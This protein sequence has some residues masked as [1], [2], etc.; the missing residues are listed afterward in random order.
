[1]RVALAFFAALLAT[2]GAAAAPEDAHAARSVAVR[3]A[4]P[5]RAPMLAAAR[6][7]DRI[8]SVGDYG[9]VLYS[10][11]EGGSW[12]QAAVPTRETLTAVAFV[13]PRAGWAVGHGGVVL[14]TSDGGA[15]W[16]QAHAAGKDAVFFAI[17][18]S[19]PQHGLAVGAFGLAIETRDGGRSWQPLALG[20]GAYA[21]RHLYHVFSGPQ[22]T[23]WIAAEAG[24]VFCSSDGGRSFKSLELPYKGS[25]WGGMAL[26]DG[27]LLVWGLRGSVLHSSDLGASWTR[28]PSGTDQA[29]T[30]AVQAP[31]GE[32]LVVGL[33]G[34]VARSRNLGKGFISQVLAERSA[35][36]AVI[37]TSRGPILFSLA[38]V[39]SR[40][41]Q[42]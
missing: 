42:K 23:L 24:T 26:H 37:S 9:M 12:Q 10:D 29:L 19:G 11:D 3:V 1:M 39:A 5:T 31:D 20:K 34:V 14:A 33:G 2:G 36:T 25:Y 30:G 35:H 22:N 27:S 17:F 7:G 32:V 38:G 21:D 15:S 28:V 16:R 41:P 40:Q 8:V 13:D 6:A 4:H 18:F